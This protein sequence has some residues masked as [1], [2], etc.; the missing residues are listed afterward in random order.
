MRFVIR[1]S[2]VIAL[3][4]MF[5]PSLS[6]QNREGLMGDLLKDSSNKVTPRWSK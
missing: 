2:T 6:A 3:A 5:I 4:L 1:T